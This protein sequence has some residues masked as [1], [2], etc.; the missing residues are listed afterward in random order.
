MYIFFG[1]GAAGQSGY[2][3][4]PFLSGADRIP[5][6]QSPLSRRCFHHH[7]GRQQRGRRSDRGKMCACSPRRF[8]AS[9]STSRFN[10]EAGAPDPAMVMSARLISRARLRERRFPDPSPV[11]KIGAERR[12]LDSRG[13]YFAARPMRAQARN[14]DPSAR[15]SRVGAICGKQN[16]LLGPSE[17]GLPCFRVEPIDTSCSSG[18][19]IGG[20]HHAASQRSTAAFA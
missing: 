17:L 8:P 9:L 11:K 13:H 14:C 3:P 6:R 1:P 20:K 12:A 16:A 7:F 4:P 10:L 2:A 5:T 15:C 18:C 19:R